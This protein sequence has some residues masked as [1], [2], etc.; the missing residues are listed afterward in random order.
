[1][2]WWMLQ[3]VGP[4]SRRVLRRAGIPRWADG[5]AGV[6]RVGICEAARLKYPRLVLDLDGV[7]ESV[8]DAVEFLLV[9]AWGE[10]DDAVVD[11]PVDEGSSEPGFLD[12]DFVLGFT[13]AVSCEDDEVSAPVPAGE[14]VQFVASVVVK[15]EL[16]GE[17]SSWAVDDIGFLEVFLGEERAFTDYQG[18]VGDHDGHGLVGIDVGAG[19]TFIKPELGIVDAVFVP[20]FR[21]GATCPDGEH[22]GGEG[23]P[24]EV[25]DG[26]SV[27]HS[28]W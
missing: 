21:A 10:D 17:A 1:M 7:S 6:C 14:G 12:G 18:D 9:S 11:L 5:V 25:G 26:F 22:R 28:G 16:H 2:R 19:E 13:D 8:E 15:P 27:M 4:D 23:D 3:R 20:V 24:A